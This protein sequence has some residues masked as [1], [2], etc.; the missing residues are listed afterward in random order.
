[1]THVSLFSGIGGIDLAAEEAG[2]RT[3]LQVEKDPYCLRVLAKHWPNV[4]RIEDIKDV[5]EKSVDEPVTF[6]SGGFP[7]QPFSVA[8]KR[9]GTEDDRYLWP[10]ML[11]VIRAIKPRWILA[12]NVR[13]ILAIEQ[14]MVIE[15]VLSEMEDSGYEIFPP[16]LVPA[17][18]VGA[19]HQ[20]YRVFIVAYSLCSRWRG[21]QRRL[22]ITDKG[23]EDVGDSACER[24]RKTGGC[25]GRSEERTTGTSYVAD[26]DCK[27]CEDAQ[28]SDTNARLARHRTT[29]RTNWWQ[30]EPDVG[31]VAHGIFHRVDRLRALGNAV[32]P[33][34]VLP[35][36]QAIA[37]TERRKYENG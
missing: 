29:C 12:E 32:V 9:R 5:N 14:G 37:E 7:C 19:P 36:L 2:F 24:F 25:V 35:I 15:S 10:E 6:I 31:R 33:A 4:K 20:R 18:G 11:R 22:D 1:V 17:S 26:T 8:G 30:S 28:R 16:I 23:M 3:I 27:G 34:Q 21:V 13:G